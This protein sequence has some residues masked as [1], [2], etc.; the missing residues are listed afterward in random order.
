MDQR[1]VDRGQRLGAQAPCVHRADRLVLDED[2][3][4]AHE[5]EEA[6]PV[7][8]GVE[9]EHDALLPRLCAQKRQRALGTRVVTRERTDRPGGRSARRLDQDH[10]RPERSEDVG[11]ELAAMVGQ[12]QYPVGRQHP[13]DVARP[14]AG[15]NGATPSGSAAV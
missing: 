12:I 15:V 2:V 9:V 3:G 11:G 8:G 1:V 6:R 4:A 10:L 14:R 7:L 5:V 13:R